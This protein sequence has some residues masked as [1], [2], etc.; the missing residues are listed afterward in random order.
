MATFVSDRLDS[1]FGKNTQFRVPFISGGILFF[2]EA[3]MLLVSGY[4]EK[5]FWLPGEG[6]GVFQNALWMLILGDWML[7][8]LLYFLMQHLSKISN[9][10]P[11]EKNETSAKYLS[12]IQKE[13]SDRV[14]LRGQ[15]RS[16]ASFMMFVGGGL[17]FFL[18]NFVRMNNPDA[19]FDFPMFNTSDHMLGFWTGRFILFTSWVML[20]PY[21]AYVCLTTLV[22]V[23]RLVLVGSS[24]PEC[25]LSYDYGHPDKHGGFTYLSNLNVLFSLGLFILLVE[26]IAEI[27]AIPIVTLPVQIMLPLVTGIFIWLTFWF[28]RPVEK[29]LRKAK[30]EADLLLENSKFDIKDQNQKSTNFLTKYNHIKFNLNFTLNTVWSNSVLS[31]VRVFSILGTAYKFIGTSSI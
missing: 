10:F 5:T 15:F 20:V 25:G 22:I 17:F 4:I 21:L 12:E 28:M 26:L 23:R 11:M 3:M 14:F 6:V 2:V 27:F 24:R 30:K 19:N 13:I 18:Y 9:T 16:W 8:I 1:M 29:F 7:L 31:G